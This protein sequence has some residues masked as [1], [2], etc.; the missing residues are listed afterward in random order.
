VK[1]GTIACVAGSASL[2]NFKK[3][4]IAIA[5]KCNGVHQLGIT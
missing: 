2:F 4:S 1:T 5:I 3:E